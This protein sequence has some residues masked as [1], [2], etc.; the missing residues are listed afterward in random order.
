M[1]ILCA[2]EY[3]NS[4]TYT[5]I[6]VEIKGKVIAKTIVKNKVYYILIYN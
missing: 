3:G 5:K 4:Q 2:F 6:Y 1:Y